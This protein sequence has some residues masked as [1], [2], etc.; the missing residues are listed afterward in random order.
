MW[1]SFLLARKPTKNFVCRSKAKCVTPAFYNYASGTTIESLIEQAGGLT[2]KASIAKVDVARRFR[3]RKAMSSGNEVAQFTA[4]ASKMALSSMG[5]PVLCFNLLM[6]SYVRTSPGYIE[7]KHVEV[8]GEVQFSGTYVITKKRLSSFGPGES[9]R[10]THGTSLF[11]GR[12]LGTTANGQRTT[13]AA[14][15]EKNHFDERLDRF[16]QNRSRR[17]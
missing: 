7:Q 15:I 13:E 17:S 6:S 8:H 11:E 1:C 5:G 16:T 14:R 3:D 12:S 10:W 2:D 4:S 9:C